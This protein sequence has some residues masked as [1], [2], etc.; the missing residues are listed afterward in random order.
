MASNADRF[1]PQA[2]LRYTSIQRLSNFSY[3]LLT[4]YTMDNLHK[5]HLPGS[6]AF[7]RRW[8]VCISFY[9][10]KPPRMDRSPG[11]F[12]R[13]GFVSLTYKTT[14]NTFFDLLFPSRKAHSLGRI[15][16][17]KLFIMGYNLDLTSWVKK[18]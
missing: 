6:S 3:Q 16:L 18:S 15:H 1:H 13:L 12:R 7:F 9:L 17:A 5:C 2:A 14:D 4:Q 8:L 11:M 10:W